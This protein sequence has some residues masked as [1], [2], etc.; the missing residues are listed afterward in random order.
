VTVKRVGAP[1]WG[2]VGR[3]E[4]S[5]TSWVSAVCLSMAAPPRRGNNAQGD[6]L[7]WQILH[8]QQEQ[9]LLFSDARLAL[10]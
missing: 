8:S 1:S 6:A 10:F 3:K 2:A 4:G 7:R 5:T 9:I